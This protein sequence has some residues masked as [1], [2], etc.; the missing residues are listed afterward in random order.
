[1]YYYGIYR[2]DNFD[3]VLQITDDKDCLSCEILANSYGAFQVSENS[4]LINHIIDILIPKLLRN[5]CF[6]NKIDRIE[7][8]ELSSYYLY[9]VSSKIV[10]EDITNS[11]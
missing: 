5:I 4:N 3:I 6:I 10:L 11:I 9:K 1:M 2:N 8:I 7:V